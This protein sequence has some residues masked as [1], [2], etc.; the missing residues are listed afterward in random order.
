MPVYDCKRCGFIY[1]TTQGDQKNGV[2]KYTPL[3]CLKSSLCSECGTCSKNK[4]M[5]PAKVYQGLEVES[6]VAFSGKSSPTLY[7]DCLENMC[8]LDVGAGLGRVGFSFCQYPVE[9][10]LLDN[11]PDMVKRLH[12]YVER[13]KE[14][15]ATFRVLDQDVRGLCIDEGRYDLIIASEGILQHL[16][17]FKEQKNC[18]Y[19]LLTGLKDTGKLVVECFLPNKMVCRENRAKEM[20]KDTVYF[21]DALAEVDLFSKGI[22]TELV[23]EEVIKDK[24]VKRTRLERLLSLILPQDI[25]NILIEL[26]YEV[27]MH[28]VVKASYPFSER[29]ID[30]FKVESN[31]GMRKIKYDWIQSGYPFSTHTDE[32]T[33]FRVEIVKK[34]KKQK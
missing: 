4:K 9:V 22:R 7:T 26:A 3:D 15:P 30:C 2:P 5:R 34:V 1:N 13:M 16:Q 27:D 25:D 14:Y 20:M 12:E 32:V 21:L 33:W 28:A 19:Q 6:Y 17:T 11:S 23:I 29:Q 8:I 18:L 10:D 31:R 24:V